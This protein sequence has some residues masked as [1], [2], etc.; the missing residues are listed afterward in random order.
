MFSYNASQS[1]QHR[2]E[3]VVLTSR[4]TPALFSELDLSQSLRVLSDMYVQL[5]QL[6]AITNGDLKKV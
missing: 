2:Q 6:G 5:N 4:C 1:C 3:K